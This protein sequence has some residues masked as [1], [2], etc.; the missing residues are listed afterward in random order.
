MAQLATTPRVLKI[1]HYVSSPLKPSQLAGA[2]RE[3]TP[4]EICLIRYEPGSDTPYWYFSYYGGGSQKIR[5]L[6]DVFVPN[7]DDFTGTVRF[8]GNPSEVYEAHEALEEIEEQEGDPQSANLFFLHIV[9][10]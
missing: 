4:M 8:E 9:V 10:H 2:H 6:L 5:C 1:G 7:A 3:G